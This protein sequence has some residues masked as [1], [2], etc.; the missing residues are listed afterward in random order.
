MFVDICSG[1]LFESNI[2]ANTKPQFATG[3]QKWVV[4]GPIGELIKAEILLDIKLKNYII[5]KNLNINFSYSMNFEHLK[6]PFVISNPAPLKEF[7]ST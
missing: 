2:P 1:G 5:L 3:P 7:A 4:L 6:G